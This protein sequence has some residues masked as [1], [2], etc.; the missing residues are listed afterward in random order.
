MANN[1]T[2]VK[3]NLDAAIEAVR[4]YYDISTGTD[5]VDTRRMMNACY[6]TGEMCISGLLASI[7]RYRGLK[8]DAS[9]EDIYKVLEVL[10]WSVVEGDRH[11]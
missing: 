2:I 10:G 1:K 9:N 3:A 6:A 7:L 8:E 11:E 4:D 5:L